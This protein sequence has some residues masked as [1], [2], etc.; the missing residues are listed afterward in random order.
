MISAIIG[1]VIMKP[2][3]QVS[4]K[5]SNS[6]AEFTREENCVIQ[7]VATSV[8]S[9]THALGLTSWF[10]AMHE[11]TAAKVD[12]GFEKYAN[13]VE[14]KENNPDRFPLPNTIS[15]DVGNMIGLAMLIS[16]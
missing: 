12:L 9:F 2:L 10:F 13:F 6:V 8:Q 16:F 11:N 14:F 3:I 4:I 1:Y 15:L 5:L 7:G